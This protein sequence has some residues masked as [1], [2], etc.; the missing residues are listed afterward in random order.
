MSK[1]KKKTIVITGAGGGIGTACAEVLKEY[2]LVLTDYSEAA[3]KKITDHF[4]QQGFDAMGIACDITKKEEV[5]RLKEFALK[6]GDFGGMVHIAGVSGSGLDPKMVF[7][8]DLVGTQIIIDSFYEVAKSGTALILFSS[9]MGHTV[10]P[11]P[12]YDGAL[13]NPQH[14]DSFK[15]VDSFVE[16][17]ADIMYN[18]AK[19]GVLLLCKDNAF[20]YGENGGRIIS[21]SPGIIMT[22]MAIKAAEEH[23][24]EINRMTKI[25]SL[26]RNGTPKDIAD[27]VKFLLSEEAGF[28][29]GSDI[30]IDGGI[31]PQLLK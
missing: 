5:E 28:I 13:R 27:V 4:V 25:T 10:P 9:I 2:K 12:D 3:V 16:G 7:D 11:N 6:Q 26:R 31:L 18:F 23:P 29:T 20:R 19:R 8:I 14:E 22:P 21:V 17:S 30:L 24:E 1:Q 15:T